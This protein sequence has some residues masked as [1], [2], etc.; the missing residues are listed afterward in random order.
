MTISG[1]W[2]GTRNEPPG[3][4]SPP[5]TGPRPG[6]PP[7]TLPPQ[8]RHHRNAAS[9]PGHGPPLPGGSRG[10]GRTAV[11]TPRPPAC[12]PRASKPPHRGP[13]GKP[14]RAPRLRTEPSPTREG[15]TPRPRSPRQTRSPSRARRARPACDTAS[16]IRRQRA[17]PPARGCDAT[18][19]PLAACARGEPVPGERPLRDG[20]SGKGGGE[21]D[22]GGVRVPRWGWG[23][24]A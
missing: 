8:P 1:A 23:R 13:P 11:P 24:E 20:I 14:N 7:R 17:G 9:A 16:R 4:L 3:R 10:G 19:R 12:P 6:S 2:A 21:G 22:S 15:P 5:C 18:E